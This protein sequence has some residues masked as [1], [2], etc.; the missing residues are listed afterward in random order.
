MAHIRRLSAPEAESHLDDLADVL[1]DCVS[2]GAGVGFVLPFSKDD[3]KAWWRSIVPGV[4]SGERL[5][6]AAFEGDD[7]VGTVQLC[8]AGMPNQTHRADIAKMLV[9]SRA[10]RK[11]IGAALMK[12]A[13]AHARSMGRFVLVLDTVTTSDARRLYERLGWQVAG[14][15]PRFARSPQGGWDD[16]LFMWKA[17]DDGA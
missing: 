11:G 16:T 13:E 15:V 14:P 9:H 7:L 6:F 17:L 4:A 5:L 2:G 3:A 8:P 1:A 12:A 10:R